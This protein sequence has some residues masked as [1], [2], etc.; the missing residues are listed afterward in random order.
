[1]LFRVRGKLFAQLEV[2]STPMRLTVRCPQTSVKG[3]QRE[4]ACVV[5]AFFLD[6]RHWI[7]VIL[8]GSLPE[9]TIHG[10]MRQSFAIAAA[11]ALKEPGT[12]RTS[13]S[14]GAGD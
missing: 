11:E 12:F 14:S 4:H 10:F 7:T 2:R 1:M 13:T 5:P 9:G 6:K 8:N 3:L